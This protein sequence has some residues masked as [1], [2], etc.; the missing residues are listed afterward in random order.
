M[1]DLAAATVFLDTLNHAHSAV[2]F[3]M[4]VEENGMLPFLGVQLLNRAPRIETKVYVKP[5]NTGL[6]LHYHSHVDS[7]YKH[8]LLVTMLDRAHRLTSSWAHFS[9]ECERLRGVFRKL[10]YSNHL[11]DSVINRFI[12][13]RVALD[14]PKQ[15]T[16]DAIG[17]VIPYKDQDAALSVKRQLKNL[18]SKVQ[19]TIQ[20]VFTSR[21]L[22]QD[23]SLREPKPNTL[24][25]QCIVYLFKCD[26]CDAGYVGYTKGHCTFTRASRDIVK[27]RHL[28]TSIIPKNITLLFRPIS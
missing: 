16:D 14:Q 13:S 21:K 24:T 8:G 12:T 23:L 17:I 18:S 27:R 2:S 11:I 1:P 5:T 22:K 4:E 25:Q 10:R 19:K 28:F 20:L 9:E 7:R 3:T 15:H 26:L 6:L